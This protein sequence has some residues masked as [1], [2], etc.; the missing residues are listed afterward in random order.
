VE[1]YLIG[2][3]A[4]AE[5]EAVRERERGREK[6]LKPQGLVRRAMQ[7]YKNLS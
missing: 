6:G 2:D 3:L 7:V 1:I 5:S 4:V